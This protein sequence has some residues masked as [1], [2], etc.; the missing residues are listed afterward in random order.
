MIVEEMFSESTLPVE[1]AFSLWRA[2]AGKNSKATMEDFRQAIA[3]RDSQA[4]KAVHQKVRAG[5]GA[6]RR[7]DE[8]K[9]QQRRAQGDAA[10]RR[11]GH[12]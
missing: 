3:K 1:T 10:K 11:K 9:K 8:E 4:A 5:K 12:P 6:R 2:N 7:R